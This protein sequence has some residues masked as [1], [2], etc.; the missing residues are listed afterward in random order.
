M[1]TATNVSAGDTATAAQY[2]ALVTDVTA[3]ENNITKQSQFDIIVAPSGGDYTTLNAALAAASAGD[4]IYI[5]AG[6]YTE[7]AT[8]AVGTSLNG[9]TVIG[10]NPSTTT[11]NGLRLDI[12]GTIS[13]NTGS[14]ATTTGDA[15][16]TGSGTT[17]AAG[18]VGKYLFVPQ[19]GFAAKIKTFTS[20]TSIPIFRNV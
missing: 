6:T 20:T 5:K 8:V 15:T 11:L 1:P 16:V 7:N 3:N 10:E 12:A 14:V 13:H 9:I 2:N 19:M 18:D 17:F 4:V